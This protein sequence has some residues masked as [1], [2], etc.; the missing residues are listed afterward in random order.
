MP[1]DPS[2]RRRTR[3]SSR[4]PGPMRPVWHVLPILMAASLLDWA[5]PAAADENP[6]HGTILQLSNAQASWSDERWKQLFDE[7]DELALRQLIVQWSVYQDSAFYPSDA[8]S[9]AAAPTLETVLD[10]A[11][12]AGLSVVV[13]LVHEPGFEAAIRRDPELVDVY[14]RR[15]RLRH[16]TAARELIAQLGAR[17][18]FAGWYLPEEIDDVHWLEP[19]R[20][21]LLTA[22]LSELAARLRELSPQAILAVSGFSNGHADPEALEKLWRDLLAASSFDRVLFQDGIGVGKQRFEELPLYLSAIERATAASS[23]QL[24]VVVEVFRQVDGPPLNDRPF[25]AVPASVERVRRQ[26]EIAT[27]HAPSVVLFAAPEYLSPEQGEAAARLYR[28]FSDRGPEAAAHQA[29]PVPPPPPEPEA[30]PP[31][32]EPSSS[33]AEGSAAEAGTAGERETGL[34]RGTRIFELQLGLFYRES[35]ARSFVGQ[36]E[37]RGLRPYLVEVKSS[38]G[39]TR[40]TVRLGPYPSMPAAAAKAAEILEKEGRQTVIRYRTPG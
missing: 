21:Q 19:E 29:A 14:L 15:L 6:V 9:P 16:M 12:A 24:Q 17:P 32:A 10:R 38:K 23:R 20:R 25:R 7:L 4:R 33:A 35:Q 36:L 11:D 5:L 39:E 40:Y 18:S 30:R 22:H 26:L 34:A 13:G 27:R 31:S 1:S 28:Y 37:E 2:R 3:T 8:F